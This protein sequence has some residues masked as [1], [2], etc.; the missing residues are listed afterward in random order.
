[1][2]RLTP[3]VPTQAVR[4]D[5][6]LGGWASN[7][8]IDHLV[9]ILNFTHWNNI[10]YNCIVESIKQNTGKDTKYHKNPLTR[11]KHLPVGDNSSLLTTYSKAMDISWGRR[12]PCLFRIDFVLGVAICKRRIRSPIGERSVSRRVLGFDFHIDE[13]HIEGVATLCGKE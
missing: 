10:G 11:G 12:F 13:F 7:L 1:L 4:H 6:G 3:Q 2:K 9:A 5:Q 8:S